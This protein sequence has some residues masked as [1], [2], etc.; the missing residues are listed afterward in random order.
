MSLRE[1]YKKMFWELSMVC[2]ILA[3]GITVI[4]KLTDMDSISHRNLLQ[5]MLLGATLVFRFESFINFHNLEDHVMGLNYIFSSILADITLIV[6]L[7]TFPN[8]IAYF[9]GKGWMM[10]GVY[11]LLR[12][13][14]TARLYVQGFRSAKKINEKLKIQK[15]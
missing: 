8:I 14:L 11:V 4:M 9:A 10:I 2:G 12:G 13:A 15:M 5:F 7:T 6:L 1:H 3:L